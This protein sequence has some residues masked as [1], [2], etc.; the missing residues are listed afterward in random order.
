V[1]ALLDGLYDEL[2]TGGKASYKLGGIIEDGGDLIIHAP[3]MKEFSRTHGKRIERFGYAPIERIREI[4]SASPELSQD[5]CVAAHLAHV[6]YGSQSNGEQSFRITLS[7]AISRERCEAAKLSY[8]DPSG[9]DI[10]S[11]RDDADTLIVERAGRD[12]YIV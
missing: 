2:W 1:V 10:E 5:L 8:A 11:F 3:Q 6:A 4:V 7:S 12:L 9:F